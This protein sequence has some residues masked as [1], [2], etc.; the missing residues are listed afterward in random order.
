MKQPGFNESPS[1]WRW[2]HC[3]RSIVLT[4]DSKP[5]QVFAATGVLES[6][7]TSHS[8][9]FVYF[10]QLKNHHVHNQN[11]IFDIKKSPISIELNQ[12]EDNKSCLIFFENDHFWLGKLFMFTVLM[13]V[14][15]LINCL[16]VM[17][18]LPPFS[19]EMAEN[20]TKNYVSSPS[21]LWLYL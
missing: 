6:I 13:L 10:S 21:R 19:A 4:S 16:L 11:Q 3:F 17:P 20:T 5:T 9:H 14:P 2:Q 1:A 15:L 8:W 7:R 12:F 18:T